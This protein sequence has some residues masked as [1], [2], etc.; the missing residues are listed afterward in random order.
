MTCL[1]SRFG[2]C[3]DAYFV[4]DFP[5]NINI[6]IYGFAHDEAAR[7]ARR[8]MQRLQSLLKLMCHGTTFTFPCL[9]IITNHFSVK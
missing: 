7:G 6:Y 5:Y 4:A 1:C 3:E 8:H 9:C 2:D